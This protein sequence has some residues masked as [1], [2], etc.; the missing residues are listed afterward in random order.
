[1]YINVPHTAPGFVY[2]QLL[3]LI[4]MI[5]QLFFFLLFPFFVLSFFSKHKGQYHFSFSGGA[6]IKPT[7]DLNIEKSLQV[8]ICRSQVWCKSVTG[9]KQLL[10]LTHKSRLRRKNSTV[11][12]GVL[13]NVPSPSLPNFPHIFAPF[14]IGLNQVK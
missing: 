5:P 6:A 10:L 4:K 7:Q 2:L 3:I 12:F 14:F 9:K 13:A 1:M 8:N 11:N